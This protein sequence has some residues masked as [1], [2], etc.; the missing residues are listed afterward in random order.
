MP[1]TRAVGITIAGETRRETA[2]FR[3]DEPWFP[4]AYAAL[5]AIGAGMAT[6]DS[7]K[8]IAPFT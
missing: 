8:A 5:E 7:W 6:E 4:A 2:R 3:K 1:W